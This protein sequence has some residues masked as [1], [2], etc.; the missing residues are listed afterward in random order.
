MIAVEVGQRH[1][2]DDKFRDTW[3]PG[4]C[5]ELLHGGQLVALPEAVRTDI[6]WHDPPSTVEQLIEQNGAIDPAAE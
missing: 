4:L 6:K 2:E 3:S 5:Q 1:V